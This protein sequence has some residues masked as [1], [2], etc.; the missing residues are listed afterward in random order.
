[1][2]LLSVRFSNVQKLIDMLLPDSI[3]PKYSVYY[4]GYLVLQYLQQHGTTSLSD[5]FVEVRNSH[6]MN[7]RL[8]MFTLD[9]LYLVNAAVLN[10]K[11]E[12]TLC[13]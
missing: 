13:S 10:E 7:I 8:L 6:G 3:H 1:M 2:H 9:W 5:L 4:T 12:V 11:G